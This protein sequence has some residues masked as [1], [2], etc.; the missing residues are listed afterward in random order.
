MK[1]KQ[2]VHGIALTVC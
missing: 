1:Q 2:S